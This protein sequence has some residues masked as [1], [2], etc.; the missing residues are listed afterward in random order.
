MIPEDLSPLAAAGFA[1]SFAALWGRGEA[2]GLAE[3][4]QPDGECLTV[5]GTEA[6]GRE[7]VAQALAGD[8]DGFLRGSRLVTGRTRVRNLTGGLLLSQRY[9]MSGLVDADGQDLGRHGLAMSAV[10]QPSLE[11]LRALSVVLVP[12]ELG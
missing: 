11:G 1:R 5:G 4:F 3:L 8:L 10:L 6:M 12:L 9:V 7:A 2:A